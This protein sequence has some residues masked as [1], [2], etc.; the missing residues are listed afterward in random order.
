M[1]RRAFPLMLVLLLAAPT[2]ASA[3]GVSIVPATTGSFGYCDPL[4]ASGSGSG[5]YVYK[6]IPAF[7]APAGSK[8]SFDLKALAGADIHRTLSLTAVN[9]NGTAAGWQQVVPSS[10]TPQNPRGNTV[11]G[12]YELTF[13]TTAPFTFAGGRLAVGIDPDAAYP[14]PC[15][16]SLLGTTS[17]DASNLFVAEFYRR[18]AVA[19]DT[20]SLTSGAMAG[21]DNIIGMKIDPPGATAA[22]V[23]GQLRVSTPDDAPNT[24]TSSFNSPGDFSLIGTSPITATG[25]G[26]TQTSTTVVRCTGV[27]SALVTTGTG[28]DNVNLSQVNVS[29]TINDA[30]GVNQSFTTGP[31]GDTIT[32]NGDGGAQLDGGDGSDTLNGSSGNDTVTGGG[33]ADTVNAGA[34]NDVILE[35]TEQGDVDSGGDGI[36]RVNYQAVTGPVTVT[37]D[38]AANDGTST[39]AGADNVKSD[40]E[41]VTGSNQG[42]SLTGSAGPNVFAGMAGADTFNGGDGNDFLAGGTPGATAVDGDVYNGDSGMDT[43]TYSYLGGTKGMYVTLND[44][45][46]DSVNVDT[47]PAFAGSCGSDNVKTTIERVNGTSNADYLGGVSVPGV[48]LVGFGGGDSLVGTAGADFLDGGQDAEGNKLNCLGGI[49]T[50]RLQGSGTPSTVTNCENGI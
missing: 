20:S 11:A 39:G 42:D 12:D 30:G 19:Q 13:T 50:Y 2:A 22:V 45:D 6:N 21:T 37:L 48:T 41:A 27:T 38:D 5:G 28:D 32:V 40:V 31:A 18:P 33:G 16:D 8:L 17:A 23:G 4:V 1:L 35:G 46:C 47:P 25:P 34:G 15:T 7:V 29:T 26:C 14:S 24:I 9:A 49:D 36:D 44:S 3:A 43:V 10:Q